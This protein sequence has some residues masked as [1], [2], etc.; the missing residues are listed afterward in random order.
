MTTNNPARSLPV[1]RVYSG[2]EILLLLDMAADQNFDL[3]VGSPLEE[4]TLAELD[5]L[6]HMRQRES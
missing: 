2:A 6:V 3:G 4:L 5:A 1:V